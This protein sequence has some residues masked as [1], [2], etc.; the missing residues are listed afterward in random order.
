MSPPV[1]PFRMQGHA[2]IDA[3]SLAMHRAIAA[4]L[5]AEP[6]L[7][8]IAHDNLQRW[9]ASAGRSQPY[10]HAWGEALAKPIDDLCR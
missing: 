5:I 2:R 8:A 1:A 4:K 6:G 7:L 3:R 9:G 10:L